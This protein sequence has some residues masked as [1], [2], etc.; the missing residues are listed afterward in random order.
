MDQLRHLN[1][2]I[3]YSMISLDTRWD[4]KAK[5]IY[6]PKAEAQEQSEP[7]AEEQ[8]ESHMGRVSGRMLRKFR[9]WR[10][11][12]NAPFQVEGKRV[13][14]ATF[15]YMWYFLRLDICQVLGTWPPSMVLSL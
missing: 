13:H 11:A 3:D 15:V 14:A 10:K 6:N 5:R 7:V 9:W 8:P 12:G 2:A 1:P 4:P